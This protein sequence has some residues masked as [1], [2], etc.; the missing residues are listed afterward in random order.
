[1]VVFSM[2]SLLM[3]QIHLEMYFLAGAGHC[4]SEHLG[5]PG[6]VCL[7]WQCCDPSALSARL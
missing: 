7:Y 3:I 6:W 4:L 1:M 5:P 2:T